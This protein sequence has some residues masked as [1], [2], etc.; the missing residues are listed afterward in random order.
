MET[1]NS[2]SWEEIKAD[3]VGK[4][5]FDRTAMGVRTLIVR[6]PGSLCAYFGI[7]EDHLMANQHY[8]SIE[9]HVHGGFTF[10]DK[11][12]GRGGFLPKGYYWYGWDYSHYQDMSL[13]DGISIGREGHPWLV[14]E[15][16]FET[17]EALVEFVK[18]MDTYQGQEKYVEDVIK[19]L[20]L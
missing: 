8:E 20:G 4:I 13:F 11:G 1:E 10:G 2:P 18:E 9:T 3:P 16:A 6:G 12:G 15:V 17:G 19:K 14:H 7:P 5:Y